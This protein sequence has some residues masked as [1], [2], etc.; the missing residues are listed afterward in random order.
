[1]QLIKI[2]L[3]LINKEIC[4]IL[5]KWYKEKIFIERETYSHNFRFF[6]TIKIQKRFDKTIVEIIYT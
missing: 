3:I 6:G 5:Y 2:I 1:M 4:K